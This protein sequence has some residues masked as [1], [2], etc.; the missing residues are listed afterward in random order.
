MNRL[1]SR[2]RLWIRRLAP[3]LAL[4]GVVLTCLAVE[5]AG[6]TPRVRKKSR[7]RAAK[8]ATAAR[9]QRSVVVEAAG[10]AS[11]LDPRTQIHLTVKQW[12][13]GHA[14]RIAG[15]DAELRCDLCVRSASEA[16]PGEPSILPQ[17]DVRA[18]TQRFTTLRIS[19]ATVRVTS[20]SPFG[21]QV[22]K[23]F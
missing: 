20:L 13:D 1:L 19:D 6:K 23:P 3:L 21:L 14:A 9:P 22:R 18:L 17:I 7:Q 2:N 15:Q 5:A 11:A 12:L 10:A 16:R 8:V 4:L